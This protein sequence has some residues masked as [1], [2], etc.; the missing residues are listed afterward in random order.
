MQKF[1]ESWHP[2]LDAA[3]GFAD[4]AL[5]AAAATE[6]AAAEGLDGDSAAASWNALA[7]LAVDLM[8]SVAI[9]QVRPRVCELCIFL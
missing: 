9:S 2:T 7:E 6:A 8:H 5:V 4:A 3:A 1:R